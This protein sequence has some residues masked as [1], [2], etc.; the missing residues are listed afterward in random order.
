MSTTSEYGLLGVRDIDF[1]LDRFP[2]APELADLVERHWLVSWELPPGRS[3]SVTLLPHPCVNL[4][5]D[6]GRLGV[7][8]VGRDRFSYTYR[9]DRSGVRG[10]VPARGRSCR[11][12]AGRWRR[13]PDRCCRPSG[14]GDRPPA[15]WPRGWRPPAGVDELIGLVEAFLRARWPPEDPQVALVG[16]IVAAMLHDRTISR[17]D[18]VTER[19]GLTARSLQR[20]F[21]ATS[22]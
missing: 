20:L 7:A 1:T 13:S 10:E 12:S 22:G 21:R 6:Q 16:R 9:G 8:G 5:L 15:R 4:V 3:A 2:P 14:C 17:V 11:S 18:D 19:F